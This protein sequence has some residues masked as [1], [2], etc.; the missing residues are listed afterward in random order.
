MDRGWSRTPESLNVL[1]KSEVSACVFSIIIAID[2]QMLRHTETYTSRHPASGGSRNCSDATRRDATV[3]QVALISKTLRRT[4]R[5]YAFAK[6]SHRRQ[7][8]HA[9]LLLT[10]CSVDISCAADKSRVFIIYG[11]ALESSTPNAGCRMRDG[12]CSVFPGNLMM[13]DAFRR[14]ALLLPPLLLLLIG[15]RFYRCCCMTAHINHDDRSEFC[16]AS[17]CLPR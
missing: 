17:V 13:P 10:I 4:P 11:A 15:H 12:Y 9:V 6:I 16:E 5:L 3:R 14:R 1:S 8:V 7:E 2:A